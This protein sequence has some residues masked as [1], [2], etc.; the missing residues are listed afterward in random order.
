MYEKARAKSGRSPLAAED[1]PSVSLAP[2][3]PRSLAPSLPRSLA[4][5]LSLWSSLAAEDQPVGDVITQPPPC[6]AL[7]LAL[8]PRV[9]SCNIAS[10]LA[11][12][13]AQD[14]PVGYEPLHH[15]VLPPLKVL[16]REAS[17]AVEGDAVQRLHVLNESAAHGLR[18]VEDER[19]AA[20]QDAAAVGGL[21]GGGGGAGKEAG[22]AV[23]VVGGMVGVAGAVMQVGCGL[24]RFHLLAYAQLELGP[25]AVRGVWVGLRLHAVGV[26][27]AAG[28]AKEGVVSEGAATKMG[29]R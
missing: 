3:L 16:R 28:D 14:Q 19:A 15:L 10:A 22:A 21:G 11:P 25:A 13:A 12:L 1:Q 20:A 2:S 27:L 8:H 9:G 29:G 24:V 6:P 18:G 23:W 4:P 17:R 7:N 26:E 5:S